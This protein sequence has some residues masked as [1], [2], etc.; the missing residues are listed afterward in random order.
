MQRWVDDLG[1]VQARQKPMRWSIS[2]KRFAVDVVA[3][4][5]G[6]LLCG[7]RTVSMIFGRSSS[8]AEQ[9]LAQA[10]VAAGVR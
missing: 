3:V 10:L 1:D 9:L 6:S 5:G 2:R 4:S 8:S 7:P